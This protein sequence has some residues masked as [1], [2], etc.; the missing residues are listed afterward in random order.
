LENARDQAAWPEYYA[1]FPYFSEQVIRQGCQPKKLEHTLPA[2][3]AIV[4]VHGLSDSPY[5]LR[6]I[7][8]FF[9]L[10]LGYDVYL[11]LLQGHGL[12]HPEGM[13]G[14]LL[15]EWKKNVR[16][17]IRTA[18]L[19]DRLLAVGGL[20]TGGALSFYMACTEAAVT[21]DLYLFSAALGLKDGWL[22][23]GGSVREFLLQTPLVDL[24]GNSKVELIGRNPY[25]YESVSVNGAKQLAHL[26]G[27]INGK[28]N[29]F[30]SG[31][32]FSSRIFSV[33]TEYDDVV[34]L[35]AINNLGKIT[36][37]DDFVQY[38][39]AK[40]KKVEHAAVVLKYPVYASSCAPD[41]HPLERANPEFSVMMTAIKAFE[42]GSGRSR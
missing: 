8:E 13:E 42:S 39:I 1:E 25:R 33:S 30:K 26:I 22:G 38:I 4:L 9:H 24:I 29:S 10:E 32:Y 17:A 15:Q 35:R 2:E 6:A 19:P 23:I 11:P 21:G 3:K 18:A 34:S 37:E 20:S 36:H 5:Y 16:F 31:D 40:E 27:E 7:A 41:D 12:L 28:I 14:V